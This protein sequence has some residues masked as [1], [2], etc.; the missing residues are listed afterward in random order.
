MYLD[1][2][3]LNHKCFTPSF[4]YIILITLYLIYFGFQESSDRNWIKP[5]DY[6]HATLSRIGISRGSE[7][8]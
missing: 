4:I 2:Y 7:T 8:Q 3:I 1:Q 5:L 6:T